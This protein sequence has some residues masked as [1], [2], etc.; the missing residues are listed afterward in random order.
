MPAVAA[1][2]TR[3]G[4]GLGVLHLRRVKLPCSLKLDRYGVLKANI[5]FGV[6]SRLHWFWCWEDWRRREGD[7]GWR[8]INHCSI[9]TWSWN[10]LYVFTRKFTRRKSLLAKSRTWQS[11][12]EH[13]MKRKKDSVIKETINKIKK[14]F[15]LE[16]NKKISSN[17]MYYKELLFKI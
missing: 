13:K 4:G 17:H 12:E 1:W 11:S 8:P 2:T 6:K 7:R 16:W 15:P 5:I 9:E 3:V 10:K 14:L